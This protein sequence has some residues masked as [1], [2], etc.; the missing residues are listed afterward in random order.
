MLSGLYAE[1][2]SSL[3]E[4]S[5]VQWGFTLV[6]LLV[7][8]AI[9]SILASLLLPA[10]RQVLVT[11][12][13]IACSSNLKQIYLAE[14]QYSND[15]EAMAFDGQN[16]SPVW[17]GMSSSHLWCQTPMYAYFGLEELTSNPQKKSSVYYC[18]GATS[19]ELAGGQWWF[20]TTYPRNVRQWN[21]T[22][23]NNTP[24]PGT[25]KLTMVPQPSATVFHFEGHSS[26]WGSSPISYAAAVYMDWQ[27]SYHDRSDDANGGIK[28]QLFW[29]GHVSSSVWL[30]SGPDGDSKPPYCDRLFYLNQ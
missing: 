8:I 13:S 3:Y 24:Y 20:H 28:N 21:T 27:R 9:I 26:S 1:S 30:F 7:V 19:S 2:R 22:L 4:N 23:A 11:A 16:G 17:P 6:E 15:N 14:M 10:L 12:R 29:D 18:P 5:R 25:V